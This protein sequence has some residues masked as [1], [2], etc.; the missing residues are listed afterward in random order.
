MPPQNR[1]NW[2]WLGGVKVKRALVL[3]CS[4]RKLADAG[5]LPAIQ[6]YNG[7]AFQVLRKY[8]REND[9]QIAIFILSAKYG[10][11][12]STKRIPDYD[13]R[14]SKES[15]KTMQPKVLRAARDTIG[16]EHW[17]SV[18]ICA[19]KDYR[20]LLDSVVGELDGVQID[21]IKGGQGPRLRALRD[22]LLKTI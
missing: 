6:R 22:W 7:P 14:L 3:A 18:G 8:L 20:T 9:E 5:L 10:L 4:Q 12:R 21:F 11:I 2:A 13:V 17:D 16:A 19:G 1:E 15:A